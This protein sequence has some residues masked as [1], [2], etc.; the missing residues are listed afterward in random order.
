MRTTLTLADDVAAKLQLTARKSGQP[1]R[2]VVNEA[3]RRGLEQR[4]TPARKPF[5]MKTR[6]MGAL[7]PG[8]SLDNVANLIETIEGPLAR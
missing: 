3:L 1:F 7:Q 2:V 6:D 8:L 5:R 4:A